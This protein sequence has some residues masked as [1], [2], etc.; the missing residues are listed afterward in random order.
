VVSAAAVVAVPAVVTVGAA[1]AAAADTTILS[2]TFD[3]GTISPWTANGGAQLSVVP[4]PDGTGKSLQVSNITHDYDGAALNLMGLLT[5][6]VQYTVSFQ[7]RLADASQPAGSVHFTV[8]DGNYSWIASPT[9]LSATAWTTITG[10]YTLSASATKA[11]MYLNSGTAPFPVVLMDNVT[12]TGPAG[13]AGGG[14]TCTPTSPT[15]LVSANFDDQTLDGLQQDGGATYSYDPTTSTALRVSG[16]NGD[17]VGVQTAAL[18]TLKPG[19][20][21]TATAKIRLAGTTT[22]TTSARLVAKPAYN[23]IGNASGI[24]STGW[25]TI[26]GTFTVPSG[27]DTSQLQIYV[28]TDNLSD[29]TSTYDYYLDDLTITSGTTTLVSAT[30]EDQT[31]D[32]LQQD[33][34]PTFTYEAVPSGGYALHVGGRNGDYVGV[35]TAALSTLKPGDT[36]TATARI[37]L[38]GTTTATTSARLVA[39]PAYNWI[40]NQ[41]GVSST[42]WTTIGGSYTV[43]S[44]TDTTQ[45]Q[46]YVGTDNLTD[47]TSTYDYLLDDVTITLPGNDCGGTGGTGGTGSTCTYPTTD[48]VI[49]ST[50]EDGTADG[51]APRADGKGSATVSVVDGGQN[52]AKAL[53][54]TNRLDQGTGAGHDVTCLLQPGQTYQMTGWVR[55]GTG[56]PTDDVWLSLA[57]TVAG[58]TSY[59]TLGQFTGVSN[60]GGWTQVTQ[61]FTAPATSDSALLYFETKY[62]SGGAIGNTSDL[63]LDNLTLTKV[64]VNVQDITPIK[65]T[66]PFPVGV[67]ASD[68]E[69][70]GAPG[71]L[72]AKHFDQVTPENT[73]KPEGWY[74]ASHNFVTTNAD[75]DTL[76]TFAQQNGLR[77]YGHTLVWYQ[78]TPDW[79]FQDAQGNFLTNSPADQAIMKQRLDAHIDG[80]AKYLSDKF[81][82]FGSATNPLVSF[83]VVNE[84][85]S[86]NAGDPQGLR[87]SHWY[88]ILGD[89]YITEAFNRAE[90]DFNH[91]Y[92]DPSATRPVALFLNDYNTEQS[93]KRARVLD[94]V[95][96]LIAAGVPIDG[97][98]H[99][100]HVTM[101]TPLSSLKDAIDGFNGIQTATGHQL[102]QA[103]TELDVPTGTPVTQANLIDQGYYYQGIF[104]MLRAEYAAGAKIFSATVWGLTDGQSWRSS[105]GA[106]LVFDDSLQAKPAY[107]G[108]TDQALPAKQLTAVVFAQGS[109]DVDV[110]TANATAN[111]E[112]SQLPLHQVG[113]NAG[114]QLRWS[115]DHLTAFVSVTDATN[116]STDAVSFAWGDGT[117][118]ATVNRNGTSTGGVSAQ[119][120]S[121]STGWKAVVDLPIALTA[122][123]TPKLDVAVTDGTATS[124]WNTP[125]SLGTLQLVEPLS[126]TEIPE[127][128]TA[129]AIDGTK[130]PVWS[131]AST[132]VTTKQISGAA[133]GAKATVYQL[134]KDHY[135]YVLAD[136]TD[137]TIDV[138]SP[139]AYEQDSVEIFTDPGNAKNGSY[140]PDDAQMRINANNVVSFGTGDEAA[141][142][143]RLTSA[144]SRTATGYIVEARIDLLDYAGVGTFQGVDYEVNDGTNGARTANF[145]WAEQTGTAYQTTS[146]W[147]VGRLVI[148]PPAITTQPADQTV[149]ASGSVTFTAGAVSVEPLTVRWQSR[150][151]VNGWQDVPGATSSALVV[152]VNG[153]ALNTTQYRAVF[154][155]ADGRT[156]TTQAATLTVTAANGNTPPGQAKKF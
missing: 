10:T 118:K 1:P 88:Q 106:P 3:D 141:Q 7:A 91:T 143:A 112:W 18:S 127:A 67:A 2:S 150:Q 101:S 116:D 4:S 74:D 61:K 16:R 8:D 114:F 153:Y 80:V 117:S 65:D 87:Q 22:A 30:F 134:W 83:D 29:G 135:L 154:T 128:T 59:T 149:K 71:Q 51:W 12:I 34:G 97:V 79:F 148:A 38:A 27:T 147:G 104:D 73:M 126:Y 122:S 9:A 113:N 23:W 64:T 46:I 108:I 145:G 110:A 124:D 50:F 25:T 24:S 42:A 120:A 75:A 109:S 129:P 19:D 136:V 81:G 60:T 69:L 99:Q 57:N 96:N 70:T 85:V 21:I 13:G 107:Y 123:A 52:S 26:G 66:L 86:D 37:R 146:R 63:Y 11:N 130:D 105:S 119:V 44:G 14:G 102:Y 55:F 90:Q 139:N 77:V 58:S 140:R 40:G 49:S 95:N 82:K 20:T 131:Q 78:Q 17:Y 6:G 36:V 54:V 100:F 151:G 98:G 121:T 41:S 62:Y 93:G 144:T 152:T 53:A 138:S 137:P 111:V 132:V 48:T 84:V 72:L 33:G 133:N 115:A 5:P 45:L 155:D 35:Q 43:P 56:Q 32:G 15:T 68:P 31:L 76:M 125:G 94:L 103:V 47:G 89:S 39:K 92:A 28:G 142:T 156:A